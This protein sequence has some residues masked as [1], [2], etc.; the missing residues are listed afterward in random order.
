M[1][2]LLILAAILIVSVLSGCGGGSSGGSDTPENGFDAGYAGYYAGTYNNAEKWLF[3]VNSDYEI[4]GA[5][6]NGSNVYSL[7]GSVEENGEATVTASDETQTAQIIFYLVIAD[8]SASGTWKLAGESGEGTPVGVNSVIQGH[9]QTNNAPFIFEI[10]NQ[11]LQTGEELSYKPLAIDA[12]GDT[13]LW[14]LSGTAAWLTIDSSTGQFS[15]TPSAEGT[16]TATLSVNDGKGGSD[17]VTFQITVTN[18]EPETTIGGFTRDNINEIVTEN[19][20]GLTWQDNA[21]VTGNNRSWQNA[22]EYCNAL[23]HASFSDWRLPTIQELEG[24]RDTNLPSSPFIIAIFRNT[25]SGGQSYYWTSNEYITPD[26]ASYVNFSNKNDS[27][28]LYL[29]TMTSP[30]VRCVREGTVNP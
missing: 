3:A 24:L 28:G 15:G 26:F 16:Y 29:K 7:S 20:T 4:S 14:S 30:F 5:A 6:T 8:G 9:S 2:K 19:A 1:K 21:A 23:V 25:Y 11:S 18:D 12:D 10:N 17:S 13:L 27:G 22:V